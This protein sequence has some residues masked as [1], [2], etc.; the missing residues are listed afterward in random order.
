MHKIRDDPLRRN[1]FDPAART[2]GRAWELPPE[3]CMNQRIDR[4]DLPAPRPVLPPLLL[5]VALLGG[6]GFDNERDG[7]HGLVIEDTVIAADTAG[8]G[9]L[10]LGSPPPPL[11]SDGAQR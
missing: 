2:P 4:P 5:A 10:P 6:C 11:D 3:R 9:A 8:S 1:A 7:D